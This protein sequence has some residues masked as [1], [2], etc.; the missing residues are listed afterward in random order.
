MKMKTIVGFAIVATMLLAACGKKAPAHAK[1]IPKS[2]SSVISVDVNSMLA[3]LQSDSLSVEGILEAMKDTTSGDDINKA[4]GY[5]TQLKDAGINWDS[6]VYIAMNALPS[7]TKNIGATIQ[8]VAAMKDEAKLEAF[9]KKQPN[10]K[11][12]EKGDGYK[13]SVDGDVIIA[14]NS[15]VFVALM[16]TNNNSFG[17]VNSDEEN[18]NLAKPKT[19]ETGTV[20]QLNKIFKIK[21]AESITSIKGFNNA[22]QKKA[23]I[24]L[25]SQTNLEGVS[26]MAFAF[27]PKVKDLVDG[28]YS[29]SYINFENGKVAMESNGVVNDKMGALLKKY[30]GPE[31]DLDMIKNFPSQNVDGVVAFSF[32][33]ALIPAFVKETGLDALLGLGLAQTGMGIDDF[34]KVFKGDFAVVVSD[35]A[36]ERTA[37]KILGGS[38]TID[39][40]APKVKLIMTA[41][42]GDKVAYNKLI[43]L[44]IQKGMIIRN[45]NRLLLKDDG[46]AQVSGMAI[47]DAD[48]V[49]TIAS[50]SATLNAYLSKSQKIGL[51]SEVVAKLKGNAM[52]SYVDIEKIMGG[53]N[54]TIF[55]STDTEA[56]EMLALAKNTFKN[57]WF[58]TA[59]LKGNSINASGELVMADAKKNSLAQM[60]RFMMKAKKYSDKYDADN[61]K[62]I[63]AYDD[64][65]N[66]AAKEIGSLKN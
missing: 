46:N 47:S 17:D 30:A 66:E 21:N 36:L 19:I 25:F 26:G 49:L 35:F 29:A 14:W 57:V 32:N 43:N 6:K 12:I 33:P 42:I 10:M 58:T 23:D 55:D 9:L 11:A 44:G 15:D 20:A 62:G 48:N 60:A 40:K 22:E 18:A 51:S 34:E 24:T 63:G 28:A 54:P 27:L 38:E 31:V 13:Y 16:G 61:T 52:G 50:D 7:L 37:T 1:Y 53:F 5:Y 4:I 45:G 39:I 2:V 3:K 41:K 65:V 8:V 56:K 59:N 64:E